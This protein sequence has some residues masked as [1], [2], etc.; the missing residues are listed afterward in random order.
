MMS[1]LWFAVGFLSAFCV[2][3]LSLV[4]H[5]A[6]TAPVDDEGGDDG[7]GQD[8]ETVFPEATQRPPDM[9]C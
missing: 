7:G 3:L 9:R 2:M 4:A 8:L 1:L 5:L 6:R